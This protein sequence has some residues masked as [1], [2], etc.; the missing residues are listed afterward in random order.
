[1]SLAILAT[2]LPAANF[3]Q[4][5]AEA[6]GISVDGSTNDWDGIP[7]LSANA[8]TA[9]SLKAANDDTNLYLLVK[10]AGLSSKGNF[11]INAD[12]NS[13]TGYKA[14]GWEAS[15]AEWLVE[16]TSL[17]RYTGNGT[18]WSWKHVAS[19]SQFYRSGAAV[20]AAVA[21][22]HLQLNA[23]ST[24]RVGYIDNNSA[25]NRLP[26]AK[27]LLPAFALSGADN[28]SE[29][30]TSYPEELDS[31]LN[32]PF[33]GWAP[34]AK[35]TRYPQQ[36]K[37]V[38]AGVTWKELEPEK[39]K[40][41]FA[42]IEKTN[43][44]DYWNSKGVKVVLR[45]I[46]D[47]PKGQPHRDIPDWLYNEMVAAGE[48]PGTA[49]QDPR[50]KG[51]MGIGN[52]T[53]FSPNYNS[54][55]VIDNHKKV[56]QAI[57]DRYNTNSRPV[58]FIQIGSL[59]HWGEFHTWPYNG[60]NG[61]KNYT[62][63]FPKNEVSNQYIQHYIDAFSGKE[64]K[65]QVLIRRS[66]G[67]AKSNNKGMVMGMFNDVFG[68]QRSFDSSWGW[69]KG[70]Q[71]GYS[72]GVNAEKQPGHPD[73]WNT[74][75]SAGEFYGGSSGKIAALTDGSGFAETM[76]QTELSKVS[77]LGPNSPA[78]LA[79]GN[80]LE[81]NMNLL[82]KRM[83]YHFVLQQ[84]SYPA[85]ISGDSLQ[86]ALKVENKGVQHFPFSW[87]LEL[88][89]RSGDQVVAT[90]RVD[91]DLAKWT[92]GTRTVTDSID[93]KLLA[94]GIYEITVAIINPETGTPGVDFANTGRLADGAFKLGS[95]TK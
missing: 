33:K 86:I 37:L 31:P 94:S 87:P 41:D 77:W 70:T 4:A 8:G 67:L 64:D 39:G 53:G 20:E 55:I 45:F 29:T 27:K 51:G 15:G 92:T 9:N 25:A 76:R 5:M 88:Q 6:A 18:N 2:V 11:W 13:A 83:G 30:I 12:N 16:S 46:M 57:A 82:K 79:V 73:F 72:D 21:L 65:M 63:V 60:P 40:F 89:L 17:Y 78:S 42:A 71:E 44:F 24:I 62:G 69:Y 81:A 26:A 43:H 68:D 36:H 34:S 7:E 38:Y 80:E 1:M 95:V 85:A 14:Y 84:A 19:L 23:G 32:N 52:N 75:I 47:S 28:E 49:Y 56:I 35:S 91:A 61:E 74:R 90:K 50:E 3:K 10:G 59:G 54:P 22:A 58:A 66:V 93:V 48:S